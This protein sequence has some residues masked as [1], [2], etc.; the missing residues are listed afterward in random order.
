LYRRFRILVA[1]GNVFGEAGQE[2]VR[3][4]LT[5]EPSAVTEA[6]AR[7]KKRPR[8]LKAGVEE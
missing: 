7:L 4:S 5:V 8:L 2:Y 1:P 3:L 6:A